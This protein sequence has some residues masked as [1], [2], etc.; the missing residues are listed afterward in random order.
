MDMDE[1][2]DHPFL[3]IVEGA[4]YVI[5]YFAVVFLVIT[6]CVWLAGLVFG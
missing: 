6:G 1:F 3:D 2:R 5:F 4:A